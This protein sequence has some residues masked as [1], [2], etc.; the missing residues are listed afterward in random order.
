METKLLNETTMLTDRV[1]LS[2][3]HLLT[4]SNSEVSKGKFGC[5]FFLFSET[6]REA[7]KKICNAAYKDAIT[8]QWGGVAPKQVDSRVEDIDPSKPA[9]E[10][11]IAVVHCSN[12]AKPIC[13]IAANTERITDPNCPDIYGGQYARAQLRAYGWK[14][15]GR[16]GVSIAVDC[17]QILGGGTP[18]G[19][20][21]DITAFSDESGAFAAFS[22]ATSADDDMPDLTSDVPF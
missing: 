4:P 17:V 22:D 12:T 3:P 8:K 9:P 10:G 7:L 18:L 14:F 6:D 1:A 11:A 20:G 15:G 5:D 13:T 19:G 16:K 2:Y 21:A